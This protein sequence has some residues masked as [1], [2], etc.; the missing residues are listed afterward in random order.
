MSSSSQPPSPSSS[1]GPI[2]GRNEFAGVALPDERGHFG[3]YGGRYVPEMLAPALEELTDAYF[4]WQ[5]QADIQSQLRDLYRDYSGRP[6]PLYFAKNLSERLGGAK[7][8]L[9]QEGLGATGAHKINHA[10]HI[11]VQLLGRVIQNVTLNSRCSEDDLLVS[12][13]LLRH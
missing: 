5:E 3:I 2:R 8:Y 11:G 10:H 12:A 6:T 4:H 9:K 13:E 1:E 7:I